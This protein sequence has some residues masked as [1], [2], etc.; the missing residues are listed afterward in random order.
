MDW[1]IAIIAAATLLGPVLAVQ[2]QKL[3]RPIF[4]GGGLTPD[5]V[6]EAVQKVEPF[7]VDVSSGVESAPGIKAAEQVAAFISEVQ[8]ADEQRSSQL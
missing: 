1:S 4:L 8:K 6:A 3:C 7:A 5:N 2:A